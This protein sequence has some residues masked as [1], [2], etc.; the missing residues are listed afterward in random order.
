MTIK[1][2]KVPGHYLLIPTLL[3]GLFFELIII[4]TTEFAAFEKQYYQHLFK[5]MDGSLIASLILLGQCG[6]KE[7]SFHH[8]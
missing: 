6:L 7:S 1:E 5:I 2:L 3:L 8:C 4:A